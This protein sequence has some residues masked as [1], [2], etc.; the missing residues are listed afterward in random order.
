MKTLQRLL[1]QLI[2]AVAPSLAAKRIYT[3]MSNPRIRKLRA[4]EEAVLDKAQKERIEFEDFEIQTYTWGGHHQEI[5]FLVHGWEGQAGNFGSIVE[6][7][8]DSGYQVKAFDAPAHGHSSKGTTSTSQFSKL[9]SQLLVQYHPKLVVSHS[10]G[11]VTS[12]MA[13]SE[14]VDVPVEKWI[15][16]TTPHNYKTWVYQIQRFTGVHDRTMSKVIEQIESEFG[17]SL[18]EMNM[19][20][21]GDKVKH[22]KDALI[23]HSKKDRVLSIESAR[24]AHQYLPQSRLIEL[25][26]HG[27]YSILW[28]MS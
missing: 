7:L 24:L 9:V 12:I 19:E 28:S 3:F 11:S 22:I 23:V 27:H 26:N 14:H 4:F 6:V 8:V 2:D 18:H 21:F 5:A 20:F 15:L 1:F 16:V 17:L 10:F 13:M 25:E